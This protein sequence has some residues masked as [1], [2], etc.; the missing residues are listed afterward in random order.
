MT[1]LSL[2]TLAN[3]AELIGAG[4]I[5]TG[6]IFGWIQLRHFRAERRAA[7][8]SGLAQTFYSADLARA[9]SLIHNVPEG[10]GLAELRAMGPEF[11]QAAVT[12]A[13]SFETMGILVFKR[14][15]PYDL[16]VDLA[17]GAIVTML[18]KLRQPIQDLRVEQQQPSWGEWFEWLG[19][20]IEKRAHEEPP[21]N[22]SHRD[23][24]P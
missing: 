7:V 23:W 2:E 17:G 10:I 9:I 15:A 21:A 4:T 22:V 5:V 16:V 18:R 11:E 20:Q 14:I 12:V 19:D 3:W 8:A 6:A 13:T 1:G 24:Q